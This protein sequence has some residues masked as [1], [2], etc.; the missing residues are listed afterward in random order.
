MSIL[1]DFEIKAAI[2]EGLIKI[3]PYDES[4]VQSAS[5]DIRLGNKFTTTSAAGKG[6]RGMNLGRRGEYC[7]YIDPTDPTTFS[8]ETMELSEYWLEPKGVVLASM[9]EDVTIPG[10]ISCK[11][12]GKSSLA[13]L[14]LDNSSLGMWVDSGWS[15]V[16]TMEFFNQSDKVIRLVPG[17]K[18]GQI[19]F[20]KHSHAKKSYKGRYLRQAPGAGSQGV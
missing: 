17:M 1:V 20:F 5:L 11:L 16:L 8:T 2:R 7:T 18:C 14:G 13:R 19:C 15:G 12:F 9:L 10:N 3:D 6:L 4:L